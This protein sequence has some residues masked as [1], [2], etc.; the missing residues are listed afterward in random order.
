MAATRQRRACCPA[1]SS[2]LYDAFEHPRAIPCDAPAAAPARGAAL[3]RRRSGPG[4]RRVSRD[5]SSPTPTL[6]FPYVMVEQHEQQ[7]VE[8]MLATHQLR[9]AGTHPRPRGRCA[10]A[11]AGRARAIRCWSPPA[12]SCSG[13]TPTR[14]RGRSARA[15]GTRGRPAVVPD[16]PGAGDQRRV[17]G[18]HRRGRLRRAA[19]VVA[20]RVGAPTGRR[21]RAPAVLVGRRV[22][23]TLRHRRGRRGRRA[24]AARLLLR[25]RG[26][27]GLGWGPVAHRTGVGEGLRLGSRAG[28]PAPL[29]VGVGARHRAQL[30]T[31]TATRCAQRRWA[32]TRPVLRPMASSR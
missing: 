22:A 23:A 20:A 11:R 31:S 16:R 6:L 17:A 13:S 26:L 3:H 9:E 1:G 5:R 2:S 18:L 10:A 30:P 27:R 25:G 19:L 32:R 29:A 21:A 7:H 14:S 24:G 28:R 8:T 12:N 15:A 4:P